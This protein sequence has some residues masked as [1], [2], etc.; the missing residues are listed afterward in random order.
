MRQRLAGLSNAA[1]TFSASEKVVDSVLRGE[2]WLLDRAPVGREGVASAQLETELNQLQKISPSMWVKPFGGIFSARWQVTE[3]MERRLRCSVTSTCTV[4]SPTASN[5]CAKRGAS[6]REMPKAE[7]VFEGDSLL[8]SDWLRRYR[9]AEVWDKAII[10][11]LVSSVGRR[12]EM[13]GHSCSV[14]P[15]SC[16]TLA[17]ILREGIANLAGIASARRNRIG[18]LPG[19]CRAAAG[20][21][22]GCG[23]R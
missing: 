16:E 5:R 20:V 17:E 23:E 19:D 4:P 1:R 12:I 15:S 2:R 21:D 14:M 8:I 22:A 10:G 6:Y 3:L 18:G 13:R 11:D 9:R 7:G